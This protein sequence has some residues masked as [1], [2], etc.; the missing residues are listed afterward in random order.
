ML[1]SIALIILISLTMA[2]IFDRLH[3]PRLIAFLLSGILLGPALLNLIHP[4][5]LFNASDLRTIALVVILIRAGLSLKF[6]DLKALGL[7]ALMLAFIPASI[8]MVAIGFIA[9]MFFDITTLEAFMLGAVIAAVSPAVIVPRM[10]KLIQEKRGTDKKLPQ[11]VLA[12]ASVDDVFVI[13]VFMSLLESYQRDIELTRFFLSI[14]LTLLSGLFIGIGIGWILSLFF[15]RYHMR[16][17]MKVLIIIS[18]SFLLISIEEVTRGLL[19]FS[20]LIAVLFL[21]ISIDRFHARLAE[22]LVHKFEKVWI[23]SE[24]MLFVLIGALLE[25]TFVTQHGLWILIVLA[26]ALGF[27]MLAVWLVSFKTQAIRKEKLF[28]MIAYLPKATVQAAIGA[29]PLSLN[30]ESGPLILTASVLSILITAPLGAW[31]I[32]KTSRKWIN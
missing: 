20:G 9:P 3:L 23:I 1:L 2:A 11:L 6:S 8:E 13:I 18:L 4:N 25:F 28:L 12:A 22:R 14:P 26:V 32:D 29:I 17:T 16:D 7:P 19:P 5:L 31:L 24:I 10:I 15:K 27:R 21:A 30:M